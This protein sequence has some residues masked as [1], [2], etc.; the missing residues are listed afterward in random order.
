M[1]RKTT[2]RTRIK[3]A[4]N[5]FRGKP[6]GSIQYGLHIKRCDECDY[7]KGNDLRDDLL[8]TA[9]ARAAYMHYD[10]YIKLPE[11]IEGEADLAR[12]VSNIADSYISLDDRI[13][14]DEYVETILIAKYGRK[15]GE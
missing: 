3:N 10:G 9:G 5:A 12:I 2:L 4:I 11:G 15:K 6:I 1:I 7:K 14:F 13:N 8:V